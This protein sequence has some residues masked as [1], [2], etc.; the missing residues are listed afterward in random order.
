MSSL[1]TY[2]QCDDRNDEF[3]LQFHD[4]LRK[5][6]RFV[7]ISCIQN[8]SCDLKWSEFC[9]TIQVHVTDLSHPY[10]IYTPMH[11]K[12]YKNNDPS[13]CLYDDNFLWIYIGGISSALAQ[14]L[15][16]KASSISSLS[17]TSIA[18][19]CL[20]ISLSYLTD[21]SK[22]SLSVDDSLAAWTRH[23][24]ETLST[25]LGKARRI[26]RSLSRPQQP[27]NQAVLSSSIDWASAGLV[28][29]NIYWMALLYSLLWCIVYLLTDFIAENHLWR[30][31]WRGF[32][33]R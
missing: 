33:G 9:L 8:E 10:I 28:L 1:L 32:P 6:V 27:V 18:A 5:S 4:G 19:I 30:S 16:T 22:S 13:T 26:S 31:D 15:R 21:S 29:M 7:F 11:K 25:P 12:P 2:K 17:G 3:Y 23:I 14:I 24:S 20:Y